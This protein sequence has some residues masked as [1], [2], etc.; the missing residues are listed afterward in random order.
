MILLLCLLLP[1]SAPADQQPIA[2]L[3][4][5]SGEVMVRHAQSWIRAETLPLNLYSGDVVAT[6][7]GRAEVHFLRDDSTLVLDVGTQLTIS[8]A[9]EGAAGSA[10]RRIEIFLGDVWFKLKSSL[11]WKTELV[12]PTAVGGLRGT[13]GWIRVPS[14]GQSEFTLAEGE[15]EIV[16]R[17]GPPG[18][19]AGPERLVLRAGYF[20]RALRG[21]A[22]ETNAVGALPARPMVQVPISQ[23]PRP[24][25]KWRE[26]IR[27]AERPPAPRQVTPVSGKPSRPAARPPSTPERPASVPPKVAPTTRPPERRGR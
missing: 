13:E 10:L 21:R 19:A 7:R 8:E 9:P 23:L 12:T 18:T 3:T 25:K 6:D 11:N 1:W 20:L 16:H 17:H 26:Q 15:L 27:K 22:L 4:Q 5:A 24:P 14:E 2:A